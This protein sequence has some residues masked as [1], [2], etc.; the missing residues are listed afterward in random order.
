MATAVG[1]PHLLRR[2]VTPKSQP[3][4]SALHNSTRTKPTQYTGLV[5][6][7]WLQKC[8][9]RI[10]GLSEDSLACWADSLP[11]SCNSQTQGIRAL[12]AEDMTGLSVSKARI[13]LQFTG[14]IPASCDHSSFCELFPAFERVAAEREIHGYG[15]SMQG[16]N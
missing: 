9:H 16:S 6:F 4:T 13:V 14:N 3:T 2:L 8:G 10:V 7:R 5:V 11:S 12:V 15:A 1:N